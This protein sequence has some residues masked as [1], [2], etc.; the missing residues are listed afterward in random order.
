MSSS[1]KPPFPHNRQRS[2]TDAPSDGQRGRDRPKQRDTR[3]TAPEGGPLLIWGSHAADA[4]LR[5]EG[6]DIFRILM[7]DSGEERLNDALAARH[8]MTSAVQGRLRVER[9]TP[10][11]LDK[12]LGEQIQPSQSPRSLGKWPTSR[13]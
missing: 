6:R 3:K 1:G 13:P 9:T 5:N 12:R 11:V 10:Q 7:T 8:A 4:A 2:G